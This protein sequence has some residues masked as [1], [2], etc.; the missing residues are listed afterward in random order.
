LGHT[1]G[2]VSPTLSYACSRTRRSVNRVA[3]LHAARWVRRTH[4]TSTATFA[5]PNTGPIGHVIE[6]R[7]RVLTAPA[8]HR[9]LDLRAEALDRTRVALHTVTL[10]DDAGTLAAIAEMNQGLIIAGFG[11]GH[12]PAGLAGPL[13]TLAERMPVVLTSRTGS[14]SVLR[15]TY[16]AIGSETDL[17]R[18]GLI[19]GGLL[20]PYKARIL[21]R[22][23]LAGGADQET[24]TAA[25]TEHG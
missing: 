23:L 12:V 20:N 1:P 24:I 14:G 9:T 16:G 7:T 10:D 15:H 13:E 3:Q 11:V 19:N 6:G 8:R 4:S 18:R 5:S 22:L 2:W 25:F 21:L 17:Q